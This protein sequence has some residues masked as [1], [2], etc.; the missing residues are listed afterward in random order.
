MKLFNNYLQSVIALMI[1]FSFACIYSCFNL[2]LLSLNKSFNLQFFFLFICRKL[3]N[4]FL[5]LQL[6]IQSESP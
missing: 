1:F 3:N 6:V 4:T 2:V 5:Y